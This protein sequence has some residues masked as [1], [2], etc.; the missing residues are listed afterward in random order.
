MPASTRLAACSPADG[1]TGVGADGSIA[2]HGFNGIDG[3][4]VGVVSGFAAR[5]ARPNDRARGGELRP[6]SGRQQR[7]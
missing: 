1:N 3:R 7:P 2:C 6:K 4:V 5:W